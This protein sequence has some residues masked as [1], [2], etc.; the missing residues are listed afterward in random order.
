VFDEL[1]RAALVVATNKRGQR[2]G[3][4]RKVYHL[5]DAVAA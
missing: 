3:R 4:P 2:P 1:E 5:A